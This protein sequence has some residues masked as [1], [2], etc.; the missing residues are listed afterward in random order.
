MYKNNV[1]IIGF[2]FINLSS[3]VVIATCKLYAIYVNKNVSKNKL[4]IDLNIYIKNT[5]IRRTKILLTI[6][7]LNNSLK[8]FTFYSPFQSLLYPI[9][10]VLKTINSNKIFLYLKILLKITLIIYYLLK[11]DFYPIKK[12]HYSV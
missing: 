3:L 7:F 9:N 5:I 8:K 11:I 4:S 6:S 2:I 12:H 1:I 10:H